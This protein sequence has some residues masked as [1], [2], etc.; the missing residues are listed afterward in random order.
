MV[1]QNTVESK[2]EIKRPDV[3]FIQLIYKGKS[4]VA[5]SSGCLNLPESFFFFF[6]LV[7]LLRSCAFLVIPP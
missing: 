6:F 5:V 2:C 1:G 7:M 4:N 3:D